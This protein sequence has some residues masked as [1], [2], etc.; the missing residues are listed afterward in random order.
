MKKKSIRYLL[1]INNP[2][3]HGLTRESL[4]QKCESLN[5]RYFCMS[6]EIGLEEK[7]P[8]T[9][10]YIVFDNARSFNTIK[11]IF[12][13][14]H[15]DDCYGTHEECITYVF[16]EGKWADDKKSDTNLKDT[17]YEW[18]EKPENHQ[19]KRNDIAD[20]IQMVKDGYDDL[21][22]IERYPYQA[23][24]MKRLDEF[25]NRYL[26]EK[27]KNKFIKKEVIFIT[28]PTETGKSSYV[29][30]KYGYENVYRTTDYKDP[31]FDYNHEEVIMFDEFKGAESIDIEQMNL[32]TDGYPM[33]IHIRYGTV[34]STYKKVY[35]VTNLDFDQL[36][37]ND[38]LM[39]PK[40]YN[41]FIRRINA[42]CEFRGKSP[43]EKRVFLDY[44][45]YQKDVS[46]SLAEYER[47]V[48]EE[49][50]DDSDMAREI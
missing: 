25:R 8:H 36:Y 2:S 39:K 4:I 45:L 13:S 9:H 7:T 23:F 43:E 3:D 28:G 22:I 26:G 49:H 41:A 40:T 30:N 1:T 21:S 20:V 14:A 19:G 18:G 42:F 29:M 12:D 16:K 11:K 44:D 15:I 37:P 10:I 48:N 32:L 47:M 24:N 38:R 46:V 50:E 17:H 34:K 6:D 31:F 5:P 27:I 33:N 35:I